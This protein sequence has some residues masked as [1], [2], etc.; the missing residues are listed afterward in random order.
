MILEGCPEGLDIVCLTMMRSNPFLYYC[1]LPSMGAAIS[2]LKE[3]IEGMTE[4]DTHAE[5]LMRLLCVLPGWSEKNVQ[6]SFKFNGSTCK[7]Y[8]SSEWWVEFSMFADSSSVVHKMG[9]VVLL[10]SSILIIF[11]GLFVQLYISFL[12][13]HQPSFFFNSLKFI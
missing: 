13:I 5:R 6:I 9:V 2:S 8:V 11:Y 3:T 1:D 7:K 12:E 10:L 4:L